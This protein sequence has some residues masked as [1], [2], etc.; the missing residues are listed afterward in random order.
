M[1][2]IQHQSRSP[3]NVGGT[4]NGR[5]DSTSFAIKPTIATKE[6]A[7]DDA[8]LRPGCSLG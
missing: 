6:P 2:L 3:G 7:A 1:L 8:F 4:R 5:D